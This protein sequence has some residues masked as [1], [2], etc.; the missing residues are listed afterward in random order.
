MSELQ[1]ALDLFEFISI[2]DVTADTL[3]KAFKKKVLQVHP[4]KGG[5]ATEFDRMLA[6]FVYLSETFQRFNGGRLT[7]QNITSPDELKG[8]RVDE[9]INRIFEEFNNENFN[10]KFEE[11]NVKETH[12]YSSWLQNKEYEDNLTQGE[13]GDATQKAPTFDEKDFHKIF[14]EKAKEGKPEPTAIILH[15]EQMAYISGQT[16]GSEIIETNE[17]GYTSHI[18]N[19]PKYTDAYEAFSN[20]TISDKLP[21]YK[22]TNKNL[23]DLIAERNQ[24]ITP[25]NN[26]EL[27]AIQEYEKMKLEKNINNLSRVKEHFQYD[28]KYKTGLTNWPPEKYSK[29][30]YKGFVVDF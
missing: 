18:F 16:I 2:Y 27:Q 12:G 17:G 7:L 1:H 24:T 26:T 29:D 9:I 23:D 22:E 4:D 20:L 5:S 8:M 30:D 15:P 25:L 11:S 10:K 28:E 6:G 19:N 21:E 13:F 3:K 14:L